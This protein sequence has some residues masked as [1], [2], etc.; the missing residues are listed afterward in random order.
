MLLVEADLDW[1]QGCTVGD[2]LD[3]LDLA[4]FNLDGEQGARL[5]GFSV[6]QHR[7]RAAA[8]RVAPDVGAGEVEIVSQ[9]VDEQDPWLDVPAPLGPV[10]AHRHLHAFTSWARARAALRPRCT[11]TRTTSFLYAALPRMSSFGSAASA[12][13]LPASAITSSV[14]S[15]PMSACSA[16]LALMF[17]A[18]TAVRPM[19]ALVTLRP[20]SSTCTET[21]TVAKSPTLRSS[22]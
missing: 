17:V 5:H 18:L 10:N 14:N 3:G 20:S 4:A 8:G 22:L 12:A 2:A 1:R 9:E 21:A 16:F 11:K 13:S 15:R 19:P 6:Q 7:A